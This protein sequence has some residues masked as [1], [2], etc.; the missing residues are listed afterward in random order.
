MGA[1]ILEHGDNTSQIKAKTGMVDWDLTH[2]CGFPIME[3]QV[4]S[5]SVWK[6]MGDLG[7]QCSKL[8]LKRSHMRP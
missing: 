5:L 3:I 4:C 1:G 2:Y 7:M 6:S 8:R